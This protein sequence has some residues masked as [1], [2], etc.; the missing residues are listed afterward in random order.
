MSKKPIDLDQYFPFFL[1][2]IAN[3]WASTSS[4]LYLAEFGIGIAEW[5]V[6]ASIFSLGNAS[7]QDI[8]NLISM[9]AGAVSRAVNHLEANGYVQKVEGRF[10]GRTK[11]YEL[12]DEG[13]SIY[14]AIRKIALERENTLL[15]DLGERDR[16]DLLR[17]MRKILRNIDKL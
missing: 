2:T 1:G 16:K 5:R 4:R 3:R 6:L 13:A 11:P 12:T 7:S 8:V 9:D 17:I 15:A 14:A 10:Q